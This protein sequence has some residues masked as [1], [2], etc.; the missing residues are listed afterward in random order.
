MGYPTYPFVTPLNNTFSNLNNTPQIIL[1]T[2]SNYIRVDAINI[3]NTSDNDIRINIKNQVNTTTP[4]EIF[5]TYN[6]II[7]SYRNIDYSKNYF[8]TIDLVEKLGLNLILQYNSSLN[9]KL[10]CYSNGSPTQ[11]FD[12]KVIYTVFNELPPTPS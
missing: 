10:L 3:V 1:E 7:P 9:E 5:I 11:T 12:C 6:F 8:N 4:T 2:T